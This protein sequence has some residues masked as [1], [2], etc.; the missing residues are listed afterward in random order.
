[1]AK[2][3]VKSIAPIL[4]VDDIMRC[5]PFWVDALGFALTVT[6]P[7]E[8]PYVFAIVA[9]ESSEVM[10]QTRASV[11]ADL[12]HS[13]PLGTSIVYISVDA[14]DPVLEALPEAAIVVPRRKTFYGAD[15]VFV[16]DPAGNIIGFAALA[17]PASS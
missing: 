13:G 10:L 12:G 1:M 8:P 4:T 2:P 15:E 16:R 17:E 11:Q 3:V 9:H 14:L 5:V 6:V 7:D